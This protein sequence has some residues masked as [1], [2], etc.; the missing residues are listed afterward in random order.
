[1]PITLKPQLPRLETPEA[2]KTNLLV[3]VQQAVARLTSIIQNGEAKIEELKRLF[4]GNTQGNEPGRARALHQPIPAIAEVRKSVTDEGMVI[5]KGLSDAAEMAE[6]M[7]SRHW[8]VRAMLKTAKPGGLQQAMTLRAQYAEILEK[9][10][11]VELAGWCQQAIDS[12]D[13]V[14]LDSVIRENDARKRDERSFL[15]PGVL[16]MFGNNWTDYRTA[17]ALFD[18]VV[19]TAKRGGLILAEFENGTGKVA[20]GRIALGLRVA[21]Q[22]YQID[23][24][25]GV[26]FQQ[27]DNHN[28]LDAVGQAMRKMVKK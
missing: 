14:L 16:E 15:P 6:E 2:I 7:S 21:Q 26:I 3:P 4:A 9:A 22:D 19:T 12:A 1:M 5:V 17:K 13:P 28:R 18:E 8:S 11:M 24:A 20:T 23:E 25:G 27:P 10:G